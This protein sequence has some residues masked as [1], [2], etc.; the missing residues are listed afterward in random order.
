MSVSLDPLKKNAEQ[1]GNEDERRSRDKTGAP[2]SAIT[3]PRTVPVDKGVTGHDSAD[4][5]RVKPGSGLPDATMRL[6]LQPLSGE[7]SP[8][9]GGKDTASANGKPDEAIVNEATLSGVSSAELLQEAQQEQH[10]PASSTAQPVFHAVAGDNPDGRPLQWIVLGVLSVLAVLSFSVFYSFAVTPVIRDIPSPIVADGLERVGASP[11]VEQEIQAGDIAG[12]TLAADSEPSG[13]SAVEEAQT[14]VEES[15]SAGQGHEVDRVPA[16]PSGLSAVEEA[17]TPVEEGASAGQGQEVDRVPAESLAVQGI[18]EQP[19]V[20]EEAVAAS[21]LSGNEDLVAAVPEALPEEYLA[22]IGSA[23]LSEDTATVP[24][25]FTL[26]KKKTVSPVGTQLREAFAAYEKGNYSRAK[27]L[28]Q[29]VVAASSNN[30]NGLLGLAAIAMR[31]GDIDRAYRYY[32]YLLKLDP[33]DAIAVA[34]M[35]DLFGKSNLRQGESAIKSLL[36]RDAEAPYLHFALGNLYASES[37]WP[38]AQQAFFTAYR[39]EPNDANYALNL[40]VSLDHTGQYETALDYY[41]IA[42]KLAGDGGAQFDM[43]AVLTRV[44]AISDM[45]RP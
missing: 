10:Q 37:R 24:A 33:S 23:A 43:T 20:Q 18:E 45:Q 32:S 29:R 1:E 17:Q 34:A 40:A 25:R 27:T 19:V 15:A 6:S 13:L 26:S 14:P 22:A 7:K 16:E 31:D 12:G 35:I 5:G 42:I 9:A 8:A 28:Y 38:E 41:G 2:V 11:S 44:Q 21:A 4:E 3:E 36:S 30:R 39:I